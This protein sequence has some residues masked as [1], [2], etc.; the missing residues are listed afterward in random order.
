M[1]INVLDLFA[2]CGGLSDGFFK[3]NNFDMVCVIDWNKKCCETQIHNIS[4]KFGKEGA[5]RRVI[6][7]D[8]QETDKLLNGW[9]EGGK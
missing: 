3:T 6:H 5:K 7:F 4:H 8:I 2:G 9:K 1:K